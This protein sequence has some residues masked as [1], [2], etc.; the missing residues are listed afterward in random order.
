M[1]LGGQSEFIAALHHIVF[2]C[3]FMGD[4]SIDIYMYINSIQSDL[5][6]LCS[7]YLTANRFVLTRLSSVI[8]STSVILAQ[9]PISN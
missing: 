7:V 4:W 1:F 6:P 8:F 3:I 2:A 9:Y 5:Q